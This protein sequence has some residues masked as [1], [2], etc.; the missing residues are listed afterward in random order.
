MNQSF[1]AAINFS[2]RNA[3]SSVDTNKLLQGFGGAVVSSVGIALGAAALM[4]RANALGDPRLQTL[5]RS[6]LP[7]ASVATAGCVNVLLMRRDEATEGVRVF[8]A[9]GEERGL[10]KVAGV[11]ALTKCCAARVLWTIPGMIGP[12]VLMAMVS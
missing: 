11:D 8:D 10:S 1:N 9:E 12:P 3:S 7:F 2:N 4:R 5:V 6:T